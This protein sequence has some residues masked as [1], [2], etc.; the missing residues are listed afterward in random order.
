MKKIALSLVLAMVLALGLSALS[1]GAIV[2]PDFVYYNDG[3]CF[4]V[5]KKPSAHQ[6]HGWLPVTVVGNNANGNANEAFDAEGKLQFNNNTNWGKPAEPQTTVNP[7]W[8]GAPAVTYAEPITVNEFVVPVIGGTGGWGS[9]YEGDV[10]QHKLW[11]ADDVRGT[12]TEITGFKAEAIEHNGDYVDSSWG[13]VAILRYTFEQAITG[14]FFLLTTGNDQCLL[15]MNHFYAAFNPKNVVETTEAPTEA[16]ATEAPATEAPATEAPAT[17]AP[18]T[19][20]PVT[21]PAAD[22]GGID[23]WVWIVIGAA[24]VVVVIVVVVVT[25]KKK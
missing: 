10:T 7:G 2:H 23:A 3:T 22:N 15:Q 17:E 5:P 13:Y 14:Q 6:A 4:S 18:A 21:E 8:W 16:P 19:Q 24:V 9:A 11:M 20:A 12:W 25:K 1:V